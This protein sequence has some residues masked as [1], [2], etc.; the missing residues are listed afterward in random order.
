MI[1][2]IRTDA[3]DRTGL[4][5]AMRCLAIAQA[6]RK[7]GDKTIYA[8]RFTSEPVVKRIRDEGV[9]V[10]RMDDTG[11][12]LKKDLKQT[13]S[14]L[15]SIREDYRDL[16]MKDTENDRPED[17]WIVLDGYHFSD[18]YQRGLKQEGYSL[19]VVDDIAHLSHYYADILLNQNIYAS[20]LNY[21]YDPNTELLFG[22]EFALIRNEFEQVRK[23][24]QK[25][26]PE[27][28]EN[29][30]ITFGG[31]DSKNMTLKAIQALNH[32]NDSTLNVKI[33]L[34][35]TNRHLESVKKELSHSRFKY[36]C[37]RETGNIATLMA[38]ADMAIT[39][40]GGTCLELA[41]MG[42]PS[43]TVAI[44]DNQIRAAKG[45]EKAGIFSTLGWWENVD[46]SDLKADICDLMQ[47]PERRA[48]YR[49]MAQGL[50]D[51][52]GATRIAE[53]ID[54]CSVVKEKRYA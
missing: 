24:S 5:H 45:Y 25:D 38:W 35:P 47:N 28:A 44:S 4:G 54:R 48:K 3:T 41:Y 30:L 39:G 21:S 23:T 34:G 46:V 9:T 36:E 52:K 8:G 26:V 33:F 13:L 11:P 29:I 20:E 12:D 31:S 19:I 16:G 22:P 14:L 49:K 37:F 32:L 42:V 43:I 27:K 53:S 51:G 7:K 17:V 15:C 6:F 40:A 50:V 2:V 18:D 10:F 1:L